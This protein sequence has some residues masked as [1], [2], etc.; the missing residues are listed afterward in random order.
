MEYTKKMILVPET[1]LLRLKRTIPP[2]D[3]QRDSLHDE[4]AH[5]MGRT[6]IEPSEQL[7][8]YNELLQRYISIGKPGKVVPKQIPSEKQHEDVDMPSSSSK[9][10][11]NETKPDRKVILE[12]QIRNN[13]PKNLV[14][15]TDQLL[16]WIKENPDILSWDDRRQIIYNGDVVSGSN[17]VDL[18][19]DIMVMRK[20]YEPTGWQA[21][22]K[23]LRDMD[24][25]KSYIQN[26]VRRK[27]LDDIDYQS[28]KDS[29]ENKKKI[30]KTTSSSL[31]VAQP[32]FNNW[33]SY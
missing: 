25:P 18:F 27:R 5:V 19:R 26:Q 21:F 10:E 20:S 31:S 15:K 33:L 32:M 9:L 24:T 4:M 13:S 3:S 8:L 2:K 28:P 29:R 7:K 11:L 23:G 22:L 12:A 16:Q 14:K 1:A 6:D 17:I 30:K